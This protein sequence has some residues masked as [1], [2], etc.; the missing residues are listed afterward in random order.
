[1]RM[2]IHVKRVRATLAMQAR[3][4]AEKGRGWGTTAWLHPNLTTPALAGLSPP[5]KALNSEPHK[6]SQPRAQHGAEGRAQ[7]ATWCERTQMA[8]HGASRVASCT[9]VPFRAQRSKR[10]PVPVPLCARSGWPTTKPRA[11]AHT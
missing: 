3:A 1:M 6:K 2:R 4:C 5:S 11:R 7:C 10:V 8:G 9:H